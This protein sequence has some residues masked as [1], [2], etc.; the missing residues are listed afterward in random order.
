MKDMF[1]IYIVIGIF[2]GVFLV[3]SY[4]AIV[5]GTTWGAWVT[6]ICLWIMAMVI[7][8]VTMFG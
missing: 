5:N 7:V 8:G 3:G 2:I 1:T 6:G 4:S